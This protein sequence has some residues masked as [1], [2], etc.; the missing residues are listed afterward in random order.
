MDRHDVTELYTSGRYARENPDWHASDAPCKARAVA[1]LVR[2]LGWRPRH[3]VD[4]GCGT[5]E[6]LAALQEELEGSGWVRQAR[7]EGWDIAPEAIARA[8]RLERP[9]LRF[10]QGHLPAEASRADLLLCLD[11][12][13]HLADDVG[14]VAE[15]ASRAENLILRIPLDLSVLDV[16]RPARAV[17]ARRRYGHRHAYTRELA[18]SVLKE[19]GLE[20]LAWK[21][22]RVPPA[23]DGPRAR[24]VDALRRG[25]FT[26]AEE[27]AVRLLGG[28][29]LLVAARPRR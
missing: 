29:S 2:T 18:M 17:E 28:Y 3:V 23:L 8:V 12:F 14:F 26:L 11:T 7:W 9:R 22:H 25:L 13:E 15:L 4:V 21:H 24:A 20:V 6:V 27:P 16:W 10:Y 5:G 1:E 19:A